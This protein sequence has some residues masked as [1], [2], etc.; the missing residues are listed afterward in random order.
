VRIT[1]SKL[2]V[3][4]AA[5][6]VVALGSTAAYA[7]F[8]STGTGTGTVSTGAAGS[9]GVSVGSIA[10]TLY[11]GSGAQNISI[12]VTNNGNGHQQLNA[13]ALTIPTSG[14]PAG[15]V[16]ADF[17][18][19]SPTFTAIDLAAGANTVVAGTVAMNDTNANQNGC[20][21]KTPTVEADAS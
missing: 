4:V 12:T 3:A 19:T 21:T 18:V 6:A 7:Y 8:V 20:A 17:T 10:G 1:K 14:L 11:P 15:C 2:A 9:W 13:V 16:A 5:T